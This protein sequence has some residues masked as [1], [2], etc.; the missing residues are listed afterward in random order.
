VNPN[1]DLLMLGDG[2]AN[3]ILTERKSYTYADYADNVTT[4]GLSSHSGTTLTL[5]SVSGIGVGDLVDNGPGGGTAKS[6]VSAVDT[7]NNRLTVETTETW[8]DGLNAINVYKAIPC[9]VQWVTNPGSSPF[10]SKQFGEAA[11]IYRAQ[12]FDTQTAQITTNLTSSSQ[13][14][15]IQGTKAGAWGLAGGSPWT[16]SYSPGIR[17]LLI[18]RE[19]ASGAWINISLTQTTAYAKFAIEGV[20]LTYSDESPG[21]PGVR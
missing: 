21:S 7:I 9:T 20:A 6:I 5:A 16:T 11:V 2:S 13:A 3:D 1:S 18:P 12:T 10:I 15:T 19:A 8:I 14:E 17:P 4:L